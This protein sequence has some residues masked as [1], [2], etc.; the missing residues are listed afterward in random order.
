MDRQSWSAFPT[1]DRAA[2]AQAL[3]AQQEATHLTNLPWTVAGSLLGAFLLVFALRGV[4]P[5]ER[6]GT[7]LAA[8]VLV[9]GAR[10]VSGAL[11]RAQLRRLGPTG[12]DS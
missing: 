8:I 6:L 4:V 2:T 12:P 3:R 11:H 9:L 5:V 1:E 10:L 7:W